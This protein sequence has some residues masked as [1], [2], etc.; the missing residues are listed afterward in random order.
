MRNWI[1]VYSHQVQQ[2]NLLKRL[3]EQ[4]GFRELTFTNA[5]ALTEEILKKIVKSSIGLQRLTLVNTPLIGKQVSELLIK[6]GASLERL[7]LSSLP[8]LVEVSDQKNKP[9]QTVVLP[10]LKVL[11]LQDCGSLSRIGITAPL[12][13]IIIVEK[14]PLLTAFDFRATNSLQHLTLKA[15]AILTEVALEVP[16]LSVVTLENLTS[17]ATIDFKNAKRIQQLTLSHCAQLTTKAVTPLFKSAERLL[18]RQVHF[19][20]CPQIKESDIGWITT[21][22]K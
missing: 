1:G 20:G 8:Q 9:D 4:G 21:E 3:T 2:K 12:L 17:L 15:C 5:D 18:P 22:T 13:S 16:M 14:L 7:V 19:E 6:Y 10:Q 11:Q